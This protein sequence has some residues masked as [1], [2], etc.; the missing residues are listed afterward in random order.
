[1]KDTYYL[2]AY[3]GPRKE[4]AG[5]CALRLER[6]LQSLAPVDP[7]FA[8]W[9]K[10]VRS[11]KKALEEPLSLEPAA[12][13]RLIQEHALRDDTGHVMEDLGFTFSLWNGDSADGDVRVELGCGKGSPWVS[14]VC[15]MH[16]PSEGLV[17]ERLLTV[18]VLDELLRRTVETWEPDW[19]VVTSAPHRERV[20]DQGT[21]GLFA[22]WLTYHSRQRGRVPPLPAPVRI[23]RVEEQG[24]LIILT[25]EQLM[26]G[27]PGHVA[28][29]R[30]IMELLRRAGLNKPVRPPQAAPGP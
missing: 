1:V 25:P 6:F 26:A 9:F 8:R 27:N 14:N 20:S 22:G 5:A 13:Q 29:A 2:G 19:A 3:W 18:P 11:R 21:A 24:T 12:L 4:P 30:R 7:V 15:L 28:L 16:L 10:P 23:E 17:A